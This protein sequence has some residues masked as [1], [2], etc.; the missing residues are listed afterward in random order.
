MRELRVTRGEVT[1]TEEVKTEVVLTTSNIELIK[2]GGEEDGVF[3][4]MTRTALG[5]HAPSV[6][7]FCQIFLC[8]KEMGYDLQTV[9]LVKA[10]GGV[11]ILVEK[12]EEV[13]PI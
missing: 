4:V 8:I 6:R 2:Y 11:A 10:D 13:R 5:R 9:S 7:D 12:K 1:R 3:A